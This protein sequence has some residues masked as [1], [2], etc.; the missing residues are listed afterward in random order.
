[1]ANLPENSLKSTPDETSP[2]VDLG[3]VRRSSSATRPLLL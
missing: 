1:M 3:K 2:G